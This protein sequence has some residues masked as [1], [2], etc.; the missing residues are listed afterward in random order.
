[1]SSTEGSASAS[2]YK[3]RQI[4]ASCYWHYKRSLKNQITVLPIFFYSS[5]LNHGEVLFVLN[6]SIYNNITI[7]VPF[8]GAKTSHSNFKNF[9]LASLTLDMRRLQH[10]CSVIK[11]LFMLST[12]AK[13]RLWFT[14]QYSSKIWIPVFTAVPKIKSQ[15]IISLPTNKTNYH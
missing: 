3:T 14:V 15:Y 9:V 6:I 8:T 10:K 7:A 11:I 2:A 5:S 12:A 4:L 1:M 13:K